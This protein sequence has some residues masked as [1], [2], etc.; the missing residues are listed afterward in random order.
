MLFLDLCLIKM[1]VISPV[2]RCLHLKFSCLFASNEKAER[3]CYLMFPNFA[4]LS[5]YHKFENWVY[6]II[7]SLSAYWIEMLVL[8]FVPCWLQHVFTFVLFACMLRVFLLVVFIVLTNQVNK[9]VAEIT[10]SYIHIFKD[11][12]LFF[13]GNYL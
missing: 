1:G 5:Y 2:I 10:R 4:L 7:L 8:F 12:L 11:Q 9:F 13:N 3:L 6:L